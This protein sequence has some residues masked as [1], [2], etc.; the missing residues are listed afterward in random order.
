MFRRLLPVLLCLTFARAA[1]HRVSSAAELA[2][3]SLSPGDTVV[4]ADGSWKHQQIRFQAKG[5]EDHP[6]TLRAAT[7]GTTFLEEDSSLEIDGDHLV[8]SGLWVKDG[9]IEIKGRDNRLTSCAITGGKQKNYLHLSGQRHRVDQCLFS[10]KT[11]EGPTVQVEVEESPN[12][13]RFD[14]NH[15]GERPPLGRNG[16]ETIR[17]GYSH[18]AML[19]SATNVEHN[20]FERCDGEIEVISNKSCDNIYRANT[21]RDCAGFLTLRHGNRCRVEG[22]FFFG[23]LKRGSGGIRVIGQ[24]HVVANNYIDSVADGAIRLTAGIPDGPATGY[25]EARNVA[26]VFNTIIDSPGAAIELDAGFGSAGRTLR[27][28]SIV[29]ANNVFSLP[30]QAELTRGT[31][32]AGFHWTGNFTNRVDEHA[33]K[34]DLML[35][36]DSCEVGR[37]SPGSPLQSVADPFPG[38]TTD[39]DG[40]PRIGRFDAG[41]DQISQAPA[42]ARPLTAADTGPPWMQASR[43]NLREVLA[44]DRERILIAAEA[45]LKQQP[46]TITSHR[47]KLSEGGPNDFYSN[48]DY[49]WPDPKKPDGLPYIKR[50]GE[51]NPENFTAHRDTMREL[52]DAVAA[53]AA[54]W[55]A[56]GDPKYP[57]KA[58]A[59]LE[60]FFLDPSTRMNPNLEYAQA[61]PGVTRGRGIGIIDTLHLI[62]IPKAVEAMEN[63][64]AFTPE[65]RK[66]LRLWFSDYAKWMTQSKNGKEEAATKNNHAV[67]YFLQLAVFAGFTSDEAQ[68]AKCRQRFKDAFVPTQMAED[69]SFP[70]ELARTKPYGYSIFQLD[71][72]ATLCQVLSTSE[73][74][75]WDF[76]LADGRGIKRAVAFLHPYLADKA[77]WP[78]PHDVQ[79]WDGWPARQPCL[80]FAGL[81]C[82]E[83]RYVDLWKTLDA[84]PK[85]A[86][87]RRNIAITQPALWLAR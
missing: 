51:T 53:L 87:V 26:V 17:I 39:L 81:A 35:T 50:D 16:G 24:D 32:G 20:L 46:L 11:T 56:T 1:E 7:S 21:F 70:Q 8:V 38:I 65:L 45:A 3:L 13:H 82:R 44:H 71:N 22:N 5:T 58:A 59:L 66:G 23:H 42:T 72:M 76:E 57:A 63:S 64:P 86:E 48:G 55:L 47:A 28:E 67:A 12:Q 30:Q 6:I 25:V 75:L 74:S 27:P 79:A 43:A 40:Q 62:E 68:L 52:R 60:T 85:D 69:G 77:T 73:D 41:C 9:N 78:H 4:M 2:G 19:S 80:L 36:R 18:Q 54:A 10:G 15:F 33:R 31:Q 49:W 84:D 29:I 34:V 14:H 37:P 61:I 83:S